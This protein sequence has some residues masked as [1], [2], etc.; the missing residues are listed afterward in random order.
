MEIE[1]S[2]TNSTGCASNVPNL[3]SILAIPVTDKCTVQSD[4][5]SGL[6]DDLLASIIAHARLTA[7]ISLVAV[8]CTQSEVLLRL[9]TEKDA[10]D[11]KKGILSLMSSCSGIY[12]KT[13]KC[14]QFNIRAHL[15]SLVGELSCSLNRFSCSCSYVEGITLIA[16]TPVK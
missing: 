2:D 11:W 12:A 6:P 1:Q 13:R 7:L 16:V 10:I 14:F 15:D 8:C 5:F 4:L 9:L 3:V